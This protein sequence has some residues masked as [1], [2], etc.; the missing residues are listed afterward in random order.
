MRTPFDIKSRRQGGRPPRSENL[1]PSPR[2]HS[3]GFRRPAACYTTARLATIAFRVKDPL[4]GP[5]AAIAIGVLVARYVTFDSAELLAAMAAFSLLAVLSAWRRSRRLAAI[6][7]GLALFCVGSLAFVRQAPAP[8]PRLDATGRDVVILG[9][10]VVEPPA[11]SGERERFVVELEPHARAQMTLYTKENAPLPALHYGQIVEAD[12]RVRRPRNY[13]NPGAFDYESYLGRQNIYWT[14]SGAASSLHVLPGRCG[15]HFQKTVMDLRQAALARID[16]LFPDGYQAGM[17]QAILIGQ[18]YQLQRVWTEDYRSTGTFHALVISGTHVAVLAAFFLLCLRLFFVPQS[19]AMT[20]TVVAGWVYALITGWQTPC[21][22]S[23]AGL[24]LFLVASYFFRRKRPLNLLAA[25]AIA[26]L[27]VDARQLFEPSFQLTFLAVGFLGAFAAPLIQATSG[28]L[29]HGLAG[30]H[31]V[32]RDLALA[33]RVAQFRIELRLL[34]RTFRLPGLAVTVPARLICFVYEVVAVSAIVQ[35][36]LALPMV[37]YFHRLGVSGL[38]ANA[39]IVPIMGAIVPAGFVA[40]FTGWHWIVRLVGLLLEI[41]H[42]VVSWHAAIE[43]NWR[44]P[45]PPLWVGMAIAA[46]LIAAAFARGRVWRIGSGVT[47]AASLA[48]LLAHPFRADVRPGELEITTI[49]VGQGDS[50][51]VVFPDGKRLLVDGGGIPAFAGQT[52]SQLDVG[53]DVVAPYLWNRSFRSLDVVALSHAHDDHIGGLPALVTDFRPKEL[54]TG[55]TPQAPGWQSVREHAARIGTRIRPWIAPAHFEFG[56]ATVEVLAPLADYVPSG[57]PK[58]NDSLVLRIRYGRHAFLLS[59]DVERQIEWGM[60]NAGE[61]P[62]ADVLKVAHHGSRTSSSEEFLG[63]VSPTFAIVSAGFENSY[64]HPHPDILDRLERHGAV[65]LRT[66]LDGL[67]T[68]RSD[69]RR[70]AVGTA[71]GF[72]GRLE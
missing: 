57:A 47:V 67:I 26:Y 2:R 20:L 32:G 68:I 29:A 15:S 72:L 64:G 71:N 36:G 66:D 14:A 42:H 51:L 24:T 28:P 31:D 30:L 37:V 43:P 49:D 46:A 22:R 61:S 19:A 38:S 45:T 7:C 58:N 52:R 23:A 63:A 35:L 16:G 8:A 1:T 17:M 27:L 54:W 40:I 3:A 34:A 65:V 53:E 70:L 4:L 25:V 69:G 5:L 13:G 62:H 18:S 6:S 50:I 12:V 39:A 10:C 33:P 9:G 60:L 59:G 56:G 44:V 11:I 21:V 55:A 48:L 41:S